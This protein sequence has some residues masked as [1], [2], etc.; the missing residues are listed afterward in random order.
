MAPASPTRIIVCFAPEAEAG[1]VRSALRG[2][3]L[4]PAPGPDWRWYDPGLLVA[5]PGVAPRPE[6]V[7]RVRALS[8]VRRVVELPAGRWL[9]DGAAGQA[10]CGTAPVTLPNGLRIGA[11]E[12][13]VIA[14]PCSVESAA[15]V[16]EI[17][18]AVKEAGARALRGGTFKPR[19]SPYVFGG[20]GEAGLEYLARAREQTG[21]PIVTEALEPAQVAVVSRYADVIQIGSRSMQNAALLVLAGSHSAG[22]AVLLKRGFAATLD[23]YLQAAEHVLLGRLWAGATE[24]GLIL[25][26]RGIRTFGTETRF[27]LDIG[28][29]PILQERSRLPVVADPSHA[30]GQRRYVA[31]LACAAV[32]AGADGLLV[33]VHTEPERAWSDAAQCLD[34][35]AFR[36]LMQQVSALAAARARPAAGD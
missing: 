20:L 30:A 26:E 13:T 32:A 4:D 27:T 19:T 23:E 14:G 31:P 18:A 7:E 35:R 8:A 29:L 10:G 28:A 36:A 33:E 15:Q 24:P 9:Y 3:G 12:L 16:C 17:A 34:V 1:S 2:L 25:C 11:G 21:L 5:W 6:A 22:K